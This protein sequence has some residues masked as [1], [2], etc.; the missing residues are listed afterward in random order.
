MKAAAREDDKAAQC[1]PVGN[2][3]SKK[4]SL[5]GIVERIGGELVGTLGL[6][7]FAP[8]IVEPPF[9]MCWLH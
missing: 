7:R 2:L 4:Q 1:V 3:D 5:P 9:A 6:L 8:P